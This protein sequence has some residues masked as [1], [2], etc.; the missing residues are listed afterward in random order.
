MKLL[1]QQN[2]GPSVPPEETAAGTTATARKQEGQTQSIQNPDA[3][4]AL[5][6]L[7]TLRSEI[8]LGAYATGT[9]DEFPATNDAFRHALLR[10]DI[11][12][13]EVLEAVGLVRWALAGEPP[14]PALRLILGDLR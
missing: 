3:Q 1:R 13:T 6:S 7:A 9:A 14:R 10:G 5:A 8:Q 12:A 4:R 2:G 11:E